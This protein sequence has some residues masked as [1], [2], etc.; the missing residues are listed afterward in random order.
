[1]D[2]R[3]IIAIAWKRKLTVIIVALAALAAAAAFAY[4]RTEQYQATTTLAMTPNVGRGQGFVASDDLATLLSTYA[5]IVQSSTT[6]GHAARILGHPLDASISASTT[7]GTGILQISATSPNPARAAAASRALSEAFTAQIAT[8][9]QLLVVQVVGPPTIPTSPVAPHPPLILASGLLLGLGLGL[10]LAFTLERW[11]DRVETVQ[12][13]SDATALSTLGYLPRNRALRHGGRSSL[14]WDNPELLRMQESVRALRTNL[15]FATKSEHEVIQ[16]TSPSP[17]DGKS[18]V[19]A[20][21]AVAIA[22][23]GVP[24]LLVD[25]DLRA[26]RQHEIFGVRNDRGLSTAMARRMQTSGL[27][28]QKTEFK[29]LR[30]LP[31][32]PIPPGP[33]ELMAAQVEPLI[34]QLRELSVMVVIDTP[35]VL[36]VSD[37]RLVAPEVDL[38]LL[39]AAA[40]R[41]R[42]ATLRAALQHLQMAHSK[43]A[44]VVLNRTREADGVYGGY[45][46]YGGRYQR[47]HEPVELADESVGGPAH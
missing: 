23:V 4:S 8:K 17:G 21:L 36:A 14:I 3:D 38:V 24:T 45:G 29:N 31:S 30:V 11:F 5:A 10:A 40:G 19:A 46:R 2:L 6:K 35:P 18:T 42:A 27:P 44:G 39:V 22:S 1:M 33:T 7:A 9:N 25:A 47:V 20:N 12:D 26:P 43:V 28:I 34:E 15:Q 32:G 37:S 13:V 41:T 16:I